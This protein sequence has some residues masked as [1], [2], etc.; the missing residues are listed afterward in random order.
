MRLKVFMSEMVAN[1]FCRMANDVSNEHTSSSSMALQPGV[2][3]DLHY[4][5]P[6]NIS[7][8]CSTSPFVYSHL[9]QVR[10]RVIQPSNEHIACPIRGTRH[11]YFPRIMALWATGM[12]TE[13]HRT[14]H[15]SIKQSIL[16]LKKYETFYGCAF[17]YGFLK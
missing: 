11:S 12:C 14:E 15:F 13:C 8:P 9:S 4:N 1:M 10:R 2:G 3:L 5:T 17:L 16:I 7:F 6:A